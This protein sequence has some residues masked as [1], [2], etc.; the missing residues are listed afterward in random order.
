MLDNAVKNSKKPS[1]FLEHA[2]QLSW[3]NPCV[4]DP[5]NEG[6][7]RELGVFWLARHGG[8]MQSLKSEFHDLFTTRLYLPYKTKQYSE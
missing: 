5:L 3:C 4:V 7:L 8:E 6:Q 1:W 2:T